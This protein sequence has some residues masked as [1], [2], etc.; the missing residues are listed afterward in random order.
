[1]QLFFKLKNY[2]ASR[3]T[4]ISFVIRN[5]VYHAQLCI[6]TLFV[7]QQCVSLQTKYHLRAVYIQLKQIF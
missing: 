7:L 1:M 3:D 6:N 5:T 2:I 4:S